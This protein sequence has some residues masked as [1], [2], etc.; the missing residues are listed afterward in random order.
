VLGVRRAR[1]GGARDPDLAAAAAGD[2]E[3]PAVG[4][5]CAGR[6]QVPDRGDRLEVLIAQLLGVLQGPIT[7]LVGVLQAPAR[8]LANV[9]DA[10]AKKSEQKA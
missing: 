2:L 10:V 1:L 4:E 6:E 7:N 8:E 5:L 3:R 9:L